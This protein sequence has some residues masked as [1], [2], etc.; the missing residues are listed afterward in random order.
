MGPFRDL[1]R[2]LFDVFIGVVF[3]EDF[4][5]VRAVRVPYDVVRERA[6]LVA[7]DGT[8]RLHVGPG[9]LDVPGVADIT[10]QLRATAETW[11]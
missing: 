9:L 8:H 10:E 11:T 6:R 1:D 5:V 2:G 4:G 3:D 7:Y